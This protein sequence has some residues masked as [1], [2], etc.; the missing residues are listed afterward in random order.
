[1]AHGRIRP[2]VYDKRIW[3]DDDFT[4]LSNSDS[5]VDN[6]SFR[7]LLDNNFLL[8]NIVL[9]AGVNTFKYTTGTPCRGFCLGHY[10]DID[11]DIYCENVIDYSGIVGQYIFVQMSITEVPHDVRYNV[12]TF[13]IEFLNYETVV[14]SSGTPDLV[15][16]V[17]ANLEMRVD[18]IVGGITDH[19]SQ[20][21]TVWLEDPA[22]SNITTAV[23]TC[24]VTYAG[25]HN[26]ITTTGLFGQSV[27][28]VIPGDYT[29]VIRGFEWNET[30]FTTIT[31]VPIASRDVAGGAW[32]YFS[33]FNLFDTFGLVE[34][35]VL[36]GCEPS[37][38]GNVVHITSGVLIRNGQFVYIS[39]QSIDMGGMLARYIVIENTATTLT[40]VANLIASGYE[41]DTQ[42]ICYADSTGGSYT[43]DARKFTKFRKQSYVS[44]GFN[45]VSGE[46]YNFADINGAI[47]YNILRK[48]EGLDCINIKLI[49][50]NLCHNPININIDDITIE[51]VSGFQPNILGNHINFKILLAANNICLKDFCIYNTA[52][53]V[54]F[55]TSGAHSNINLKNITTPDT[56]ASTSW[57]LLN[58]VIT[59][60][61]IQNCIIASTVNGIVDAAGAVGSKVTI[62]HNKIKDTGSGYGIDLN[63]ITL[64]DGGSE[65]SFNEINGYA[66]GTKYG[67]GIRI[68]G[69]TILNNS[70]EEAIDAGTDCIIKGNKIYNSAGV[71]DGILTGDNC[72]IEGN[73]INESDYGI[74]P[75]NYCVVNGNFIYYADVYGIYL[76]SKNCC[77]INNNVIRDSGVYD[78]YLDNSIGNSINSNVINNGNDLINVYLNNSDGNTINGNTIMTG[79]NYN[80]NLVDS[81]QNAINCNHCD[82]STVSLIYEI[83]G[84]A[85]S[86]YNTV[87]GNSLNAN[88][89]AVRIFFA[90]GAA[91]NDIAHNT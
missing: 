52:A 23:Q 37:I 64:I 19:S 42:V 15:T 21:I 84:D 81:D 54:L 6:K 35:S 46:Y 51:G 73:H 12:K 2:N 32:N 48:E 38:T 61:N 10:F 49:G 65:V 90:V 77:V 39:A 60:L 28:S 80:I 63:H 55:E 87:I 76:N 20:W 79:D 31:H 29:I 86:D 34:D 78:V 47:Y 41:T 24:Q 17:G 68:I 14:G 33:P 26:I 70:S 67:V 18:T 7:Y 9:T 53:N 16:V 3:I 13:N 69:N 59:D 88:G 43:I 44:V 72:I 22:S 89:G 83:N 45:P 71:V 8:D 11:D 25:G 27:A 40:A 75:G 58:S 36:M 66:K 50:D 91:G 1:M 56:T 5:D 82:R 4:N 85:T 30:G 57:L 62:S 74:V